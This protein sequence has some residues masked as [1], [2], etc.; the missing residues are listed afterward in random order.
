MYAE[1]T[2]NLSKDQIQNQWIA[3]GLFRIEYLS[4]HKDKHETFWLLL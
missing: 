4:T 1:Y 2:I 3:E